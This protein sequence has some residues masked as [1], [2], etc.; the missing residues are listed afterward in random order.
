MGEKKAVVNKKGFD[1]RVME[2]LKKFVER[3]RVLSARSEM[4]GSKNI[5]CPETEVNPPTPF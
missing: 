4:G 5:H 3:N 2:A 1:D